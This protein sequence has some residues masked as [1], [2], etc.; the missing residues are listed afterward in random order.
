[1]TLRRT[2]ERWSAHA[3]EEENAKL[4]LLK[5]KTT[6]RGKEGIRSKKRERS[7][8]T[9]SPPKRGCAIRGGRGTSMN[10]RPSATVTGHSGKSGELIDTVEGKAFLVFQREKKSVL[11][12][13]E[14]R[15]GI[16]WHLKRKTKGEEGTGSTKTKS[17]GRSSDRILRE[18]DL[19]REKKQRGKN[20]VRANVTVGIRR[21]E[22]RGDNLRIA[23]R[24]RP[25]AM[26]L[27]IGEMAS[28]TR[29]KNRQ[30][31]G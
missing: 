28:Q 21:R 14:G 31:Q 15:G 17:R 16:T 12:A 13:W 18:K 29:K 23:P 27:G 25:G 7:E 2:P 26:G 9:P 6:C 10:Q 4:Y 3:E 24:K 30:G 20:A 11:K 5:K 22:Q 19:G 8:R 1:M